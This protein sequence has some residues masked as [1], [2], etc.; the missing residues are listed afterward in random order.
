[1]NCTVI[2]AREGAET[3]FKTLLDKA[4][5]AAPSVYLIGATSEPWH[6]DPGVYKTFSKKIFIPLPTEA[7]RAEMLKT[8]LNPRGP[9]ITEADLHE[10]AKQTEGLTGQR[11][12]ILIKEALFEP[13]RKCKD[14]TK[15]RVTA[16]GYYEPTG[17]DD[18]KGIKCTINDLAD[19]NKLRVPYV[20]KVFTRDNTHPI[21]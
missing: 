1:M 8:Q 19:P 7:E 9:Q 5:A 15:F 21:G 18:P 4:K 2:P 10:F 6:I 16:D 13:V 17:E 3:Y 12:S 11:I 14:A 20:T